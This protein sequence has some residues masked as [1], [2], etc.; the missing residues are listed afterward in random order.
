[1]T[2]K[3]LLVSIDCWRYDALS[4]TNDLFMTPKFDLLTRDYSLAERFFVTAPAT[5]PS[6]TSL[7]TGLYPFEHGLYGQTYLKMFGG[8]PNLFQLFSD[9]GYRTTG[10]SQRH[11]V[12]RFLDYEPFVGPADPDAKDQ[13]LG[14]LEKT[15]AALVQPQGKQF[16]FL[17]LWYA[18]GGYGLGGIAD[19]PNLRRMVQE[20]QIA[21]ALRYYYAA[22]VHLQEFVLAELLKRVDL[23][24]W[25]VF[26][27][28]DHGE[29]FCDEVM[30]H[31]D[32][33]HQN[34][35]RVPLLA[36]V[37]GRELHFPQPASMIDLFP[38]IANLAGIEAEYKGYGR[39]LLGSAAEEKRWV[40][41]ELDSLYGV[42]FLNAN[43]L[44]K[45]RARAT[46][47]IGFDGGEL[48][49]DPQG[50]RTWTLSDGEVFYRQDEKSGEQILRHIDS[51]ENRPLDDP[52]PYQNIYRDLCEKSAYRGLSAQESSAEESAVL[53]QRLR[54]LGYIE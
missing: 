11:D 6:H 32:G 3:F 17:H 42:G 12:F 41:T 49:R 35:T 5:R 20:G 9:A 30:A 21:Q 52:K 33:L 45:E 10:R 4:R 7:F 8:I 48:D 14:S 37:P 50:T 19:A 23:D 1:M 36:H 26:V 24:E 44:K 16:S 13:I 15:F 31:G 29:G 54:D 40:L 38:T 39:D 34:V 22:V 46:S 27:F 28:G 47:R 53:E 43:N 25:A 51:G 18:H 2:D